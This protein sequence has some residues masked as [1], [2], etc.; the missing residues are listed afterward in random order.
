MTLVSA[1][2]AA[3]LSVTLQFFCSFY[4]VLLTVGGDLESGAPSG[5][6]NIEKEALSPLFLLVINK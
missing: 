2:S 3:S 1:V 4:L 6:Q 5:F